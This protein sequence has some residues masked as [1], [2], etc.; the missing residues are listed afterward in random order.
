M[1]ALWGLF[2]YVMLFTSWEV[3]IVKNY[4]YDQ[5]LENTAFIHLLKKYLF[6]F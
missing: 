1:L 4:S 5:D 6:P 2:R 3:R